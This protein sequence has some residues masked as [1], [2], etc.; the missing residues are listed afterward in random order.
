MSE[1]EDSLS[2]KL[3]TMNSLAKFNSE[4]RSLLIQE[5]EKIQGVTLMPISSFKKLFKSNKN[6][7]YLIQGG[8]EFWHGINKQI[9]QQLRE[10][11]YQTKENVLIIA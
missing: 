7:L 8:K 9:V 10:P 4:D 2:I 1:Q 6:Q 5:I 3:N 11:E